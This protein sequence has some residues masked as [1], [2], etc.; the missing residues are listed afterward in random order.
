MTKSQL[1][2][3]IKSLDTGIA[4]LWYDH[5]LTYLLSHK[6]YPRLRSV[7]D[8]VIRFSDINSDLGT[9][10]HKMKQLWYTKPTDYR[11]VARA[12][13]QYHTLIT[14]TIVRAPSDAK[15]ASIIDTNTV[16]LHNIT[17]GIDISQ[18]DQR[19]SRNLDSDLTK[20]L[21]TL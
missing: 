5:I 10:I 14:P 13:T 16:L 11:M 1:I 18:W 2:S 12:L 9:T 8:K 15:T 4:Q 20:L 21:W 6:H 3:T 19:Y 7:R 17:T